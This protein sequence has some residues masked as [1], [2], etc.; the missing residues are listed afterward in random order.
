MKHQIFACIALCLACGFLKAQAIPSPE[1]LIK[2]TEDVSPKPF[3]FTDLFGQ[4]KTTRSAFD[5]LKR[6][7]DLKL[8]ERFG[9]KEAA[10]NAV[11]PTQYKI[12]PGD[13]FSFNIWGAL[14][15]RIP[16]VVNPE[17]KLSVPSVGEIVVNGLCLADAQDLVVRQSGPFYEKSTVTLTLE[18]MRVFRLH[19]AGEVAYPGT[20][21]SQGTFRV[22]EMIYEAGGFTDFAI[23]RKVELRHADGTTDTLDMALYEQ[24]G[25]LE[26]DPFVQGGDVIFIPPLSMSVSRVTV[27]GDRDCAGTYPVGSD[28][29]LMA[30]LQRIRALTKN[31]DFQK[32]K[33]FRPSENQEQET[34][35]QPFAKK[36]D[37]NAFLLHDLDRVIL[38]SRYVYVRGSVQRPGAYPFSLNLTAKDYAGMAGTTG[39]IN[40]VKVYGA[41]D[42]KIL[43]GG[44]VM[45]GPGDVVDVPE[46]WSQRI[47]DY[48]TIVSTVASLVIAGKAIG[49]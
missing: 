23:T 44:W 21:L 43:K 45:V 14:E 30:F 26:R 25:R 13:A 11:D 6:Q 17:G 40:G 19:L 15:T 46:T 16:L 49:L 48:L 32:I 2:K 18:R 8:T 38:P 7:S 29:T 12:G 39:N 10:E 41:F 37:G 1:D 20:Y 36:N 22:S 3:D 34:S 28:E 4:G 27:E 42:R 35:F 47:K 31:T 5:D 24:K 9:T 33:V